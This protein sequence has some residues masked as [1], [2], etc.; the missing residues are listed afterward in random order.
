[1]SKQ[2]DKKVLRKVKKQWVVMSM[3]SFAM[4]GTA[5]VLQSQPT[6]HADSL[7][8]QST[9]TQTAASINNSDDSATYS[10]QIQQGYTDA[11]QKK[12]NNA[13]ALSG[14]ASNYYTAAY[15]GATSAMNAYNK[16]TQGLGAGTQDYNYYGNTVV[17]Q[18]GYTKDSA[19]AQTGSQGFVSNSKTQGDNQVDKTNSANNTNTTS[20]QPNPTDGT[21]L[22]DNNTNDTNQGGADN[23]KDASTSVA[24][25]ESTM[26]G[27]LNTATN[28][29]VKSTDPNQSINVPQATDS[30]IQADRS[31][32][33]NAIGL[34]KAFDLAVNYVFTQQGQNDAETGKW[35]G[36]YQGSN[37]ATKDYYLSS[38]QPNI[39]NPYDQAYR[40]ARDAMNKYFTN[41]SYNG[42]TSVAASNTG[43][44]SYDQAFNDVVNQAANGTVFVQ[45]GRQYSSIMTGTTNNA[46]VGGNVAS[47]IQTI[48]VANDIDLSGAPNGENDGTVNTNFA[49]LTVDGQNHM[50]DFH[51]NNYT[52]NRVGNGSLDVYLQNFQTMYGAN[53]FGTFRAEPGA[54]FHF[55][56]INYVGPQLLSSY[57][58]DT[59][60]SGRVNVLVPTASPYYTSP[61]QSTVN[62][63]GNGNQENLEVNNFILEPN[64]TYFGNT[65][66]NYGGTNIVVTGNLTL[67][68]NA[69]M[70]LVPRGGNGG[71]AT[72]ADSS[73]WGIL[74]R[75]SGAS[76]NI[77]KNAIINIIPQ[78]LSTNYY[79]SMM[80]GAVYTG[81]NVSINING[82][83]LN[84]E[85]YKGISGY[86]NQPIDLQ[87]SNQTQINVINGGL[88]QVLMDSIP[89]VTNGYTF[90]GKQASYDALINNVGQG[91]FNIGSKGN[92][93]VGVTNSDGQ[94]N[95]PY[96][97]PVNINSVGSN[98]AVFLKPSSVNQ[99]QTTTGNAG[100][101]SAGAINAYSV[102][103]TQADG[104]KQYLYNFQLQSGSTNYTGVDFNGNNVS[105]TISGN[106]LDIADVPAVQFVGPLNKTNNGD[107]TTTV[108]GFARLSNYK[109]LNNSPI[110]V[111]IASSGSNGSYNSLT[112]VANSN[113]TNAYSKADPNTYTFTIDTTG[114]D[115]GLIPITYKIASGVNTNYVGM[116]LHYGINSVN[117]VLGPNAYST[118]VEGYQ[119]AGNGK[120]VE[121]SNGDMNVAN[122]SLANVNAGVSD[123]LNDSIGKTTSNKDGE[124]FNTKT[125][126]D[127][128]AAYNAIQAGYAAYS[129][130]N[131]N[132][133]YTKLDAYINSSNPSAFAQG[134]KEAAYQAGL[135][136]ARFNQDNVQGNANYDE[137]QS[138]YKAAYQ[139]ALNNPTKAVAQ[140]VKD[141]NLPT[142]SSNG[143]PAAA[144]TT[145]IADAQGAVAMTKDIQNGTPNGAAYNALGKDAGK[146]ASYKD[147]STGFNN[148][149]SVPGNSSN[150]DNQTNM[151]ETAGFNYGQSLVNGGNSNTRPTTTT[152]NMTNLQAAQ[153]GYDATQAAVKR[154]QFNGT[155]SQDAQATSSAN[156]ASDGYN[157]NVTAYKS[158]KYGAYQAMN[159]QSDSNLNSLEKTGYNAI[160]VPQ[161]TQQGQQAFM[162]ESGSTPTGTAALSQTGANA[163][164][165]AYNT[166]SASF[167]QG[168]KD[169]LAAVT[170]N[171]KASDT[172]TSIP[173]NVAD[174]TAYKTGY[175]GSVDGYSDGSATSAGTQTAKDTTQPA[176]YNEAYNPAYAQGRQTAGGNDYVAYKQP[177]ATDTDYTNGYN[178]AAQG[179]SDGYNDAKTEPNPTPTK[180]S[181]VPYV[182]G[183]NAGVSDERIDAQSAADDQGYVDG[184]TQFLQDK[185]QGKVTKDATKSD[186]YNA[187]VDAGF[188]AAA[189]GFADAQSGTDNSANI[190]N[191]S[192]KSA[193]LAGADQYKQALAQLNANVAAGKTTPAKDVNGAVTKATANDV[194]NTTMA[195]LTGTIYAPTTDANGALAQGISKAFAPTATSAYNAGIPLAQANP[196]ASS[197]NPFTVQAIK[198]YADGYNGNSNGNKNASAYAAGQA[199]KQ[200]VKDGI[201]EVQAN[202][203]ATSANPQSTN[204]INGYQQAYNDALLNGGAKDVSSQPRAY[205][206]AYAQ[207]IRDANNAG[208]RDQALT[209]VSK[210]AGNPF[211]GNSLNAVVGT[212]VYNAVAKGAS[213]AASGITTPASPNDPNYMAGF[214]NGNQ[215]NAEYSKAENQNLPQSDPSHT[216]TFNGAADAINAVNAHG[217]MPVLADDGTHSKPYVAAYN[218][219]LAQANDAVAKAIADFKAGK[220][221]DDSQ[222]DSVANKAIY[223]NAYKADQQGY[224]AGV[225]GQSFPVNTLG[226]DGY[227][228]GQQA[229]AG[230]AAA[231]KKAIYGKDTNGADQ[232]PTY[233][234]AL[235][236]IND[237]KAGNPVQSTDPA[238][239]YA[240]A[241]Q[242]AVQ[243]AL[244]DLGNKNTANKAVPT[245]LNADVYNTAYQATVDGY[246]DG[247][248][249]TVAGSNNK[250]SDTRPVYT[251]SYDQGFNAG[252]VQ[253]GADD[254][255][256]SNVDNNTYTLDANY[257]KGVDDASHG[258]Y[259]GKNKAPQA[260][261]QPTYTAG[262]NQGSGAA[263]GIERAQPAVSSDKKLTNDALSGY[264]GVKDAYAK[265]EGATT[266]PSDGKGINKNNAYTD[267]YND[268]TTDANNAIAQGAKAF[269]TSQPEPSSDGT[270]QGDATVYGY[271]RAEAGFSDA[272]K[273]NINGTDPAYVSGA[274][275]YR[276]AAYGAQFALMNGKVDT[277]A[278][279]IAQVAGQAEL[280]GLAGKDPS[281]NN[282]VYKL[283][284]APAKAIYDK[285]KAMQDALDAANAQRDKANQDASDAN[286][287]ANQAAIDKATADA[288]RDAALKAQ[289]AAQAAQAQAEADKAS[290]E[291]A[292]QAAQQAQAQ[293]EQDKANA[294]AA[295]QQ[296]QASQADAIKA[297]QQ[298]EADKASAEAQ[299]DAAIKAQQQADADKAT[300][301]AQRDAALK[302]QQDAQTQASQA[303]AD[304][305][306]AIKAMTDAKAAEAAAE[307]RANQADTDKANAVK[308]QQ[309]AEARANQA[310]TDKANA[311][312][313][314]QDAQAQASQAAT[315]RDNAIKAMQQAQAD[316]ATADSQRDDA[317]KAMQQAQGQ[318]ADASKAQTDAEA[319]R[320][321]AV[322]AMNDA[323]A[324]ADKEVADAQKAQQ[325]AQAQATQA[326]ADKDAAVK[327]SQQ[328][329]ADKATAD[330][331][332]DAA[333]KAQ[334]DAQAAQAKAEQ[335]AQAANANAT[336]AE[337]DKEA[338]IK[339][340]NDAK[341]AQANA[342]QSQSD[343]ETRAQKA[344]A[345]KA[346]AIKAEQQAEADKAK[347]LADKDAA[348]KAQQTA[349]ANAQQADTDRDNAIKAMNDANARATQADTDKANAVKAMNDA[350]A[351][352][353]QADADKDAAI[354]A[355]QEAEATA[356]QAMANKQQA[357]AQRD[358]AIKAQQSAEADKTQAIA[359]KD[360]ALKA[361]QQA[362]ADKAQAMSQR[363][364]AVKAQQSA[365]ADKATA[366]SQRDAA[367]QAQK[368]AEARADK[369]D[370][371]KS[372]AIK[373]QQQAEADKAKAVADM[374]N[375][376]DA[377]NNA[378]EAQAK[379]EKAQADAEQRAD[380]AEADKAQADTDRDNA[381]KAQQQ[382]EADKTTAYNQ[383]DDAIKA[384]NAAK[385]AQAQAEKAQADAETKMT[386]AQ[387]AQAK[388]EQAQATADKQRDD[389]LKAQRNAEANATQANADKATAD[390][391]RDDA[392]KAQQTAEQK[393]NDVQAQLVQIQH[394]LQIKTIEITKVMNDKDELHKREYIDGY[395]MAM[396]QAAHGKMASAK[397]LKAQP[398]HYNMGYNDGF[399]NYM[400]LNLPRY[401]YNAGNVNSY[402]SINFS[403]K[404][405]AH[406]YNKKHRHSFRVYKAF[407]T[408][409]GD[410]RYE[411][412]GH[413]FVTNKWKYIRPTY[414]APS[415]KSGM[416][417]TLRNVII[418]KHA[419]YSNRKRAH[420]SVLHKGKKIHVLRTVRYHGITRF[421]VKGGYITSNKMWVKRLFNID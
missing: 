410:I 67:G 348:I 202:A 118:T 303:G 77:N 413:K 378:K 195:Q 264:Y 152:P 336:Q 137:A 138:T 74:L 174:A 408:K 205:Q 108:S 320:D 201:A 160:I 309:D 372:E 325:D 268:A 375:A 84:Y 8:A 358:A 139:A 11:Y 315:D 385:T 188:S 85:G 70:T 228:L 62:I 214:D 387:D 381:I 90:N 247:H 363:D 104:T 172:P 102:A 289:Q 359:D 259:D 403:K 52:V 306:A 392:L 48:K 365:E 349:E 122:V 317:I 28:T 237:A 117:T 88:L 366:D 35:Q 329:Q 323:K 262:Y 187:N 6:A 341:T 250:Q 50:M 251:A 391:Q 322:K 47:N 283:I 256:A 44:A 162:N 332:R 236:G 124:P 2:G 106:T 232:L 350:N 239:N 313:A 263:D 364:D 279:D 99:F 146:Q 112:Q 383:R 400:K 59:Y 169:G 89:N 343:A 167:D 248:A 161:S 75:N 3:A 305:D 19:N 93:K 271:K 404:T 170:A 98:H 57:S 46:T 399:K 94:Y 193:Y 376:V 258:Y 211:S 230:Y 163:F 141:N 272:I 386:Q 132:V 131:A 95:V 284:Y 330:A 225:S 292:A 116:R 92:L 379:A 344:D 17:K 407:F 234:P 287:K 333:L 414:Y 288:Q 7:P 164:T 273:G 394:E 45:N 360:A 421:V 115:G 189:Q 38:A 370:A 76:L 267:A 265:A 402:K 10:A 194:Y 246:N 168:K 63:E 177:K 42:N 33:A 276:D 34:G 269:A 356:S 192:Q 217:T 176:V 334:A 166:A 149:M 22:G 133:D 20:T 300:A 212:N 83:T 51:G 105:G 293:A 301:E 103:I 285:Q 120:V 255:L 208:L 278:S 281:Q 316:K 29:S 119:A 342:E 223:N 154:A 321:A 368:D 221:P 312:K 97:G 395:N 307:A 171:P 140:L 328:A 240:Y 142:T 406:H 1:M 203:S 310:D 40:G 69:K 380:K 182:T 213:D 210:N 53:F 12:G 218:K 249:G 158:A 311:I 388:A 179:Y 71:A 165:G 390:K 274:N 73:T 56:N 197:D 299:R 396:A 91:S 291:Q 242:K 229:N 409:N 253:Q 308:A 130:G 87:G 186:K 361:Q 227:V 340:M 81:T 178:K 367:V 147:A 418:H 32:Y 49:T 4:V 233:Q 153:A 24:N 347:A 157:G 352:A 155:G 235:N 209:A 148:A 134:F 61:F 369:A 377:M 382:A 357:D 68:E 54:V 128:L 96:Y 215:A 126:A 314:Q 222:L 23:P 60:F 151:S 354:K 261:T 175:K 43:N 374:S 25:Y 257:K 31:Q 145:A 337:A 371:D 16:A 416:V 260:S 345:D 401:V 5:M 65:S 362:E 412:K 238:Y 191:A 405:K 244:T 319:Q 353:T 9:N 241:Q 420:N 143:T 123:A 79:P 335:D 150:P 55:S 184:A 231:V 27:K 226:N 185:E 355:Q 411:I 100:N 66:P 200:A 207:G 159:G 14:Q 270:V 26:V 373:A 243:N 64:S 113:I 111:G 282:D 198:D 302:A 180:S 415:K 199:D 80:G 15:N 304:K 327:A 326:E 13:S 72:T 318:A 135:R 114:Y 397:F 58:N 324:Q 129:N 127:Y 181:E 398:A 204:A 351:R 121:T 295:Q 296:A 107:G 389:A 331:Q 36:V 393:A 30:G 419:G 216:D 109:E 338:A 110:Y 224:N 156:V 206:D 252:R 346:A 275:I 18:D 254:Y 86:Y 101:A 82:G 125:N 384:A 136:D 39:N 219:A 298:A 277:N 339:A 190:T 21:P 220:Q 78:L 290:A 266:L 297:E 41:D 245:G 37:G 280:D 417:K 294:V 173:S 183:Y 144:V 196:K 286:A